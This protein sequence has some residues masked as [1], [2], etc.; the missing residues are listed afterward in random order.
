MHYLF[1]NKKVLR[2][3]KQTNHSAGKTKAQSKL[4]LHTERYEN[5]GL[6]SVAVILNRRFDAA[7]IKC[8]RGGLTRDS[9]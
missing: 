6:L 5:S 4:G 7:L 8:S 2:E 9:S 1:L 3:P